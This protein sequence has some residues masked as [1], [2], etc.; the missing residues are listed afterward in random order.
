MAA[1]DWPLTK[2]P[3]PYLKDL[4]TSNEVLPSAVFRSLVFA[5]I[6]C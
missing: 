3:Q 4:K 6:P 2:Q 5:Q 1:V